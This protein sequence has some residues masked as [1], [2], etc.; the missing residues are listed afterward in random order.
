MLQIADDDWKSV[1]EQTRFIIFLSTPHSGADLANWVN[2]IKLLRPSVSI[3]ELEEHNP[4]LLQLND[5]Y[6]NNAG[7]L[8][9]LSTSKPSQRRASSSSM[10]PAPIPG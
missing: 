2:Y 7:K 4:Q 1:V 8:K 9:P 10:Q 3:Q 5:W 6:S